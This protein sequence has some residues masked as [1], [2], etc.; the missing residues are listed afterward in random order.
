MKRFLI[1][2]CIIVL[3]F[4]CEDTT[5]NI[6]SVKNILLLEYTE[7]NDIPT[8]RLAVYVQL[9]S[10][11]VRIKNIVLESDDGDYSWILDEVHQFKDSANMLWV[12]SSHFVTH[13]GGTFSSMNFTVT[14]TDLAERTYIES[15]SVPDFNSID[16][17]D[18][19]EYR[20]G[21][22]ALYDEKNELLFY[23]SDTE[24]NTDGKITAKYPNAKFLRNVYISNDRKIALLDP[25]KQII[26]E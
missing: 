20:D 10:D 16:K 19:S 15:F 21:N 7:L 5:P 4:S 11:P 1:F 6:T 9:R 22:I 14:Y 18:R 23:G 24:L 8:E 3:L 13:K 2:F 17:I 25:T 26:L 12:G